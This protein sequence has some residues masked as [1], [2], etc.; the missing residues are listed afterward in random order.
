MKVWI[1]GASGFI[2]S[3][4][5]K[6]FLRGNHTVIAFVTNSIKAHLVFSDVDMSK[7]KI[8]VGD[9][10]DYS[11]IVSSMED[12][13]DVVINTIGIIIETKEQSF[14]NMHVNVVKNIVC[15]AKQR[16]I[17][18]FIHI[19]ALGTRE[20][21][22]SSYHQTKWLGEQH[23]TESGLDYTIFRPSV[24]Y[25]VG[26]GFTKKII[27][28]LSIPLILPLPAGGNNLLQPIYVLDL[29]KFVVE[30]VNKVTTYNKIIELVG[31]DILRFKEILVKVR[32][33]KKYRYKI[34][35]Y[36]PLFIM[37]I[38]AFFAEKF[39]KVPL[40]TE[41]QIT[42]LKEDNIAPQSDVRLLFPE[43]NATHFD[44]G[45]KEVL[46]NWYTI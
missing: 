46:N 25:G 27:E 8:I 42:M 2:G 13:V 37:K 20:G 28:I 45:I 3:N 4:L 7:I 16:G 19:S 1:S 31:P 36:V 23:I 35:L 9:A 15:A 44:E 14:K 26:D 21:A 10:L 5:A 32:E 11:S 18:R 29:I 22:A 40:I 30:S 33:I 12:D 24:V 34:P 41:D 39:Q 43:I 17:K 6:A 38:V